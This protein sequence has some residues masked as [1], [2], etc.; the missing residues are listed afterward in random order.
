MHQKS[1]TDNKLKTVN[2]IFFLVLGIDFTAD[3]E[4]S[5]YKVLLASTST[6]VCLNKS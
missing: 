4:T 3:A 6:V 1:T 5:V 2:C